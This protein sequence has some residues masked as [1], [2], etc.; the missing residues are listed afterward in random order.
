MAKFAFS[1]GFSQVLT[2]MSSSLIVLTAFK[3][4]NPFVTVFSLDFA[5]F[6]YLLLTASL[7]QL[8]GFAGLPLTLLLPSFMSKATGETPT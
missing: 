4:G 5:L 6:N 8:E 2:L 7:L 1:E 3:P